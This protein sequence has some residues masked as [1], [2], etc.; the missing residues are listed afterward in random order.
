MINVTT[1]VSLDSATAFAIFT[2]EI[3]QWWRPRVQRLFDRNRTGRLSFEPGPDGR[4]LEIYEDESA[5]PF[6]IGR[7]L[8]WSPP[9]RLVFQWRQA[10]FAEREST[11]VEVRF[12]VLGEERTR[13][14]IEHRGWDSL[15]KNHPA[16]RGYTGEAFRSMIGLRWADLLV[17]FRSAAVRAARTAGA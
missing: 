16:R 8:V 5:N 17:A 10:D 7:V 4:L 12:E 15:R 1:V 2:E 13:V 11:E 14:A 9:S 3:D 6:E